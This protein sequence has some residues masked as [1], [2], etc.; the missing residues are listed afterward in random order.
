MTHGNISINQEG[1]HIIMEKIA[2][3]LIMFLIIGFST[4][5]EVQNYTVETQKADHPVRFAMITDLHSNLFRDG[6]SKL[7]EAIN[8]ADPD[9]V[10]LTGDIFDENIPDENTEMLLAG[11]SDRYPCY[12]VTGNHEYIGSSEIMKKRR[13][14]LQDH[15]V[16]WLDNSYVTVEINGVPINICGISDPRSFVKGKMKKFEKQLKELTKASKNGN[17]TILLSHRSEYFDM[18]CKYDFDLVLAGHAHGGLVRIPGVMNG[19]Y[20]SSEG[21]FPKYAGGLYSNGKTNMIVGRGLAYRSK[22]V[23]RFYNRPELVIIDIGDNS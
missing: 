1:Y 22:K 14:L 15:N 2:A 5:I 11:I 4:G 3:F 6:Q 18:Y 13:Q 19:L 12:F 23:P 7:I 21:I 17:Y 20:T 10:F 9:L 8:E 16:T